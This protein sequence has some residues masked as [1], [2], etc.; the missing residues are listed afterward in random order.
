MKLPHK[1][2]PHGDKEGALPRS[3]VLDVLFQHGVSVTPT[4]EGYAKLRKEDMLV[5]F[6]LPE[7]IGGLMVRKLARTFAIDITD[8]YFH[9]TQRR[10]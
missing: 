5:V 7:V 8:F 3:V 6:D 10:H 1:D 2:D 9:N 4:A